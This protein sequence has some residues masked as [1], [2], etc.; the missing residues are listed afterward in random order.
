MK[1]I[2]FFFCLSILIFSSSYSISLITPLLDGVL[3]IP[4][5]DFLSMCGSERT[6]TV[7]LDTQDAQ[8]ETNERNNEYSI[9]GVT[10]DDGTEDYCTG[11]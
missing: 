11:Q 10:I 2:F 5:T 8:Q 6:L 9:T 1:I 4:P 3:N 7:R